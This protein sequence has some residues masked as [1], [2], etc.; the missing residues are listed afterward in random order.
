MP[1]ASSLDF[2]DPERQR[3]L[4]R[5]HDLIVDAYRILVDDVGVGNPADNQVLREATICARLGLVW[6]GDRGGV[7]ALDPDGQEVEIKTT[8]LDAPKRINFPTSRYVSQTVI[9]RFRDAGWW[10]FGVFNR[11]EE[12][13]A[14]YRVDAAHME[15]VIDQL[16]QRML[17]RQAKG[18]PLENNPKTPL[19]SVRSNAQRLYLD[20]RYAEREDPKRGWV[21][22]PR[23]E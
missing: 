4:A 2:T 19:N 6:T 7:D 10:V 16:E 15:P 5:A 20:G 21:I 9:D 13:V 22:E 1:V 12:L 14:L 17:D 18:Q 11:Y 3:R 23:P 8:R